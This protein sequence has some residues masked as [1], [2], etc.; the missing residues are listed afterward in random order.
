MFGLFTTGNDDRTE[1]LNE[2]RPDSVETA[3][4]PRTQ[5]SYRVVDRPTDHRI[6]RVVEL[7]AD[8]TDGVVTRAGAIARV[9]RQTRYEVQGFIEELDTLLRQRQTA[10][11]GVDHHTPMLHQFADRVGLT[12]AVAPHNEEHTQTLCRHLSALIA[13]DR[14]SGLGSGRRFTVPVST[15]ANATESSRVLHALENHQGDPLHHL[16]N[17]EWDFVAFTAPEQWVE[18]TEE[19]LSAYA[20]VVDTVIWDRPRITVCGFV[21]PDGTAAGEDDSERPTRRPHGTDHSSQPLTGSDTFP[22]DTDAPDSDSGDPPG[23]AG[24]DEQPPSRDAAPDRDPSTDRGATDET[25]GTP[26]PGAAVDG[27]PSGESAS[28][29]L[30]PVTPPAPDTTDSSAPNESATPS[31]GSAPSADSPPTS[32]STSNPNSNPDSD[33]GSASDSDSAPDVGTTTNTDPE[34]STESTSSTTPTADSPSDQSPSSSEPPEPESTPGATELDPSDTA[35]PQTTSAQAETSDDTDVDT[36]ESPADAPAPAPAPSP[37]SDPAPDGGSATTDP[38]S[39]DT[40]DTTAPST[41]A[42]CPPVP[43]DTTPSDGATS[44]GGSDPPMFPPDTAPDPTPDDTNPSGSESDSGSNPDSDSDTGSPTERTRTPPTGEMPSPPGGT[45]PGL[46]P[47]GDAPA[48]QDPGVVDIDE[49]VLNEISSHAVAH[50][51]EVGQRGREVYATLY[52]NDDGVIRHSHI[53]EDEAFLE[54][55]QSSITFKAQFYRYVRH[56]AQIYRN[57]SHRL[58][59]DVHSHPG[60]I[61]KQSPA[62]KAVSK[63]VWNNPRRNHNFIIALD[64]ASDDAPDRWTVVADGVE[65][66]KRVN[67]HLLRVRAFAGGTND[68]KQIR[69]H[70][71][72]GV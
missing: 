33:P 4:E 71:T 56:L 11:I 18:T 67:G 43:Q 14:I 27:S 54:R 12:L 10:L 1:E 29:E 22:T 17:D 35:T 6:D 9:K 62:D 38:T 69:V 21:F 30:P 8:P 42:P 37:D 48:S 40:P 64:D 63:K 36:D 7:L 15:D 23:K 44:R 53:I 5:S 55:R 16:G 45:G 32:E 19:T 2:P 65:V 46:V 49:H 51:G 66:R 20:P 59:G 26:A 72:M 31:A 39:D 41:P 24:S 47:A 25:P 60:G 3:D 68:P 57:I 34:P 50:D 61:P 58:C 28:P 52:C 70:T 13:D